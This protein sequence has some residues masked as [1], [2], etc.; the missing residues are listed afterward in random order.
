MP[1]LQRAGRQGTARRAR[2]LPVQVTVP[3]IIDDA[4]STAHDNAANGEQRHKPRRASGWRAPEQQPPQARQKQQPSPDRPIQPKQK[5]VGPNPGG[6]LANPAAR[7][8]VRVNTA[9]SRANRLRR[10]AGQ[11]LPSSWGCFFSSAAHKLF[12]PSPMLDASTSLSHP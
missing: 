3:H 1:H 6:Q 9:H 11:S 10:F 5:C 8:Y 12:G 2:D 4:T 7:H